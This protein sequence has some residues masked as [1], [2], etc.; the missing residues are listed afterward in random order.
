M[1]TTILVLALLFSITAI[2]QS[3]EY[4]VKQDGDT[5]TGA[6]KIFAKQINIIRLTDTIIVNSEEVRFFVKNNIAKTVLRLMLYGYTDNIE[7]AQSTSYRDPVYDTTILLTSIIN[8]ENLN[9]F[10]GKDKRKVIYFFVQRP[11]D[12]IPV[13]LL[14]SVGGNMP[15]KSSWSSLSRYLYVNYITHHRIFENQLY[16]MTGDCEYITEG[17]LRTLDYRESSLK[18]F[19][20]RYNQKCK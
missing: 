7:E 11:E 5:V 12:S 10:S 3:K 14:Y 19:I 8:G 15:E 18:T 17:N 20:K 4:I 16:D 9:L 1:K 6:V 13:Q 2:A